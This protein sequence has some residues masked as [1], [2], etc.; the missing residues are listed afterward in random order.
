MKRKSIIL[1]ALNL[2]QFCD[3]C[4]QRRNQGNRRRCSKLRQALSKRAQV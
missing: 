4:H 3:I 2:P 1:R